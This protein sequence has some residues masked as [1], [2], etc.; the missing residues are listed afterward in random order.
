MRLPHHAQVKVSVEYA[1][2]SVGEETLHLR[3]DL[4]PGWGVQHHVIGDAMH[5]RR[6]GGDAPLRAHQTIEHCLAGR[7]NDTDLDDLRVSVQTGCLGVEKEGSTSENP[8]GAQDCILTH[9][10]F[11]SSLPFEEECRTK[12]PASLRKTGSA[13]H[14]FFN[15]NCTGTI[16]QARPASPTRRPPARLP[17]HASR[18][19]R[20]LTAPGPPGSWRRSRLLGPRRRCFPN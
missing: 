4:W 19:R 10:R 20:Q 14:R 17:T 3:P 12:L 11:V 18:P 13:C 9:I 16:V 2:P 8:A 1:H 15:Y 7:I 5:R 6:V